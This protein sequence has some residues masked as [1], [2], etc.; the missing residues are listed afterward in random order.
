MTF[1]VTKMFMARRRLGMTQAALAE[2]VGVTQ[3][4]ISAWEN[5][6]VPIPETRR[7]PLARALGIDPSALTEEA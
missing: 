2:K 6:V 4:R 5:L 3:P 7:G 1:V